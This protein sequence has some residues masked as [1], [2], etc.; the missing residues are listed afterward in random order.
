MGISGKNLQKRVGL[1][2]GESYIR[3]RFPLTA[4]PLHLTW[5]VIPSSTRCLSGSGA[6]DEFWGAVE[7]FRYLFGGVAER[8]NQYTVKNKYVCVYIERGHVYIDM[9][10]SS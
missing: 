5:T 4:S 2:L 8:K 1:R 10:I 6:V 7:A 3:N 9:Y